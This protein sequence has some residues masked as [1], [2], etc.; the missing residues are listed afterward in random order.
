MTPAPTPATS[1]TSVHRTSTGHP[2]SGMNEAASRPHERSRWSNPDPGATGTTIQRRRLKQRDQAIGYP[3]RAVGDRRRRL[4]ERQ[5]RSD[6][7]AG[8]RAGRRVGAG[9]GRGA[10]RGA[11]RAAAAGDSGATAHDLGGRQARRRDQAARRSS[12]PPTTASPSRSRRSPQNLT[13]QFKTAS[14]QGTGPDI[15][16]WAHDA[17]ADFVQNSAIDPVTMPDTS[18]FDPLAV[19]GMTYQGQLYGVPYSIENI[20]LIRNTDLA[21]ECPATMEDLVSTG[22]QLVK[23]KKATNIMA[24]QVGQKGDA[25]HIY[26]LFTSGGGSFFGTTATGD[27][28]GSNV[29]VDSAGVHRG[30]PEALRPGREGRR[31]AQALRRRQE[32]HPAVHRRQDRLPRLRPV[33]HRG[34]RE[35]QGQLRR[36]RHPRRS[37]TASRRRRSSASTAST[38]PATARTRR[39]PRSSS[40][41]SSRPRVPVGPVRGRP[42]SPGADRVRRRRRR[43][44]TPTSRSS[45]TPEPTAR[46]C[47]R[48]RRWA[49]SGARSASPRPPSSAARTRRRPSRPPPRRS[50]TGSPTSSRRPARCGRAIREGRSGRIRR[51]AGTT[52]RFTVPARAVRGDGGGAIR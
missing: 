2:E 43:P 14:Q 10:V 50:A 21:P 42:A 22:Q 37:R 11:P 18:M 16:V 33:G 8:Q 38:S 19:K 7:R 27:P 20:A 46:S 47:P 49:R 45:R 35:G 23:D 5:R 52:S 44:R 51:T 6:R 29:T 13:T 1:T 4:F 25:Y 9:L 28:D 24:L 17:V 26:P 36:L 40:R 39:S 12:G 48:S 30:R 3:V 15:V 31:R 32:R 34:H 41:A